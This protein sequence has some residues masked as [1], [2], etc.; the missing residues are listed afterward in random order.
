MC[1]NWP[2][3]RL[4]E[5]MCGNSPGT[6]SVPPWILAG[7]RRQPAGFLTISSR[8]P[9]AG[10]GHR[11]QAADSQEGGG[12]QWESHGHGGGGQGEHHGQ[13]TAAG[14]LVQVSVCWGVQVYTP[15]ML[16]FCPTSTR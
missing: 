11:R 7:G 9:P 3:I 4:K 5:M 16:C 12:G 14:R 2:T 8:V 10:Q 13:D 1:E 15:L 6:A